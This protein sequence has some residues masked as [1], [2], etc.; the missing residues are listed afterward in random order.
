MATNKENLMIFKLMDALFR[1]G[2]EDE[3]KRIVAEMI[4]ELETT[5]DSKQVR[6]EDVGLQLRWLERTPDKR[7]VV[8]SSPSRPNLWY[9]MKCEYDSDIVKE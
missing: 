3:V 8:G 9:C 7:E 4:K 5:N 2:K 1:A 6:S